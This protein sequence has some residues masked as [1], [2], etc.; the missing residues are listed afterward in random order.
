MSCLV[1]GTSYSEEIR[2]KIVWLNILGCRYVH[3]RTPLYTGVA[4][5]PFNFKLVSE[6]LVLFLKLGLC[7]VQ[8]KQTLNNPYFLL[9]LAQFRVAKKSVK[10]DDFCSR[11]PM[12]NL[13][14]T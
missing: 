13:A 8:A 9:P 11:G 12:M 4:I 1:K 3:L 14:G 2:L 10:T 5:F 6:T 7:I